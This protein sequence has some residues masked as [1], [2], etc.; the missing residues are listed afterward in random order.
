MT[1]TLQTVKPDLSAMF[2]ALGDPTRL[3]IFE[4]LRG[5][6]A[7]VAVE[8]SGDVRPLTGPTV[9]D[10]CCHVTGNE[11]VT[12]S[13]SFHLK[14]L[15]LAGLIT[16]ERRGKNMICAV[17]PEAIDLLGQYFLT[18]PDSSAPQCC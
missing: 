8:D 4:F 15:R 14:E 16:M 9:G 13:I 7:P 10:I 6:G 5:C 2:K 3:R 1:V 12:S 11:R 17:S 18:K